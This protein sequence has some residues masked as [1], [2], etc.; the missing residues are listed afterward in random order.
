MAQPFVEPCIRGIITAEPGRRARERE[1]A[2]QRRSI[3]LAACVLASAMAFIDGS[4]LTV[5]LPKLRAFFHADFAS[6]QWV[7]NGYV[8][9][10]AALTLIGGALADVYGKARMLGVG[11]LGFGLASAAC[12]VA[13]SVEWLIVARVVQGVCAAILTPAS[14]ALIG[15][16]Y[17]KAER[18]RAI[19]VWAAA[20]ALTTAGGPVLGGWLT[21][22]FGW[23]WVFAINPPL[24]LIAV[25]V[26][27]SRSRRPTGASTGASI[28]RVPPSWPARW[29]RWPGRSAR[30]GRRAGQR[31]VSSAAL[32]RS[33]S[34][35]SPVTH[36]GSAS[37]TIR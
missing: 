23:Q 35:P 37:A 22:S 29:R 28:C 31:Q 10:L 15:A 12:I 7:L 36:G 25:G 14:L 5:A 32:P 8:L 21:E 3:V 18:N 13:P 1:I 9:A 2:P 30:S 20:S 34:L 6:V 24:A 26:A 17:P 19:G 11:C 27:R 4:A 33:A 16:T